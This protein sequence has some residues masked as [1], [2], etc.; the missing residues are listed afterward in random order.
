MFRVQYKIFLNIKV[1]Q[2]RFLRKVLMHG[3]TIYIVH[4]CFEGVNKHCT[5]SPR[6]R[7]LTHWFMSLHNACR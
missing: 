6:S 5:V 2:K 1:S 4:I 7:T 3:G